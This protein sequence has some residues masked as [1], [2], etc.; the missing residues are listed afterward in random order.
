ME[1]S[2]ANA[3]AIDDLLEMGECARRMMELAQIRIAGILC[4]DDENI[5]VA[6]AVS[7]GSDLA[8]LLERTNTTIAED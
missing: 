1:I 7:G 8:T 5:S 4:V 6:D 3:D 2:Q